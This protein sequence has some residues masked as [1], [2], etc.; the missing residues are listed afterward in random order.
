[1]SLMPP[2]NYSLGLGLDLTRFRGPIT[3]K[4]SG[5]AK[6]V[7]EDGQDRQALFAR[8]QGGSRQARPLLRREVSG[9]EDS[10]RSGCLHRDAAQDLGQAGTD[11]CL[12]LLLGSGRMCER[13]DT[14]KKVKACEGD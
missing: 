2:V 3:V 1:M 13:L 5:Y 10:S 11:R 9:G 12:R 4:R 14:K 8:V 7:E 6:G